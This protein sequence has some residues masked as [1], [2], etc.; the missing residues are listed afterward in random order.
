MMN[1]TAI[2]ANDISNVIS[3]ASAVLPLVPQI[4]G[5]KSKLDGLQTE[6]ATI[7][8][9]ITTARS[10]LLDEKS[11][12]L[13]LRRQWRDESDRDDSGR[14]SAEA[15]LLA[16]LDEAKASLVAVQNKIGKEHIKLEKIVKEIR[17]LQR[18]AH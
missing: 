2:L 15:D 4:E 13:E 14:R 7:T 10:A 3:C 12:W 18:A 9:Q 1:P 6:L 5:A 8:A 17:R 16:R 11:A